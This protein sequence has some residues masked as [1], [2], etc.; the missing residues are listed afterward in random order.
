MRES[1]WSSDVCSSDLEERKYSVRR[2]VSFSS[3]PTLDPLD[4]P[5][6]IFTDE[7]AACFDLTRITLNL[8]EPG[9]FASYHAYPYYPNFISEQSSYLSFSD[10]D[11]PN[12]YL[13][14]LNDLKNH[15]SSMP[16]VIAEFG[17]P[18]SW[19]SAHQSFSGMHHGGFPSISG[20]NNLSLCII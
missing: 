20:E 16:L 2:P 13:G 8:P 9:I 4:H 11:G 10:A 7:D 19:G 3:W 5:T 12:S 14:Y 6:E 15:Y 17:V 1:D 18:S